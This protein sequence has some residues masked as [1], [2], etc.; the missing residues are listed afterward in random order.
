[1]YADC[2]LVDWFI[3]IDE[4]ERDEQE[5]IGSLEQ[6]AEKLTRTGDKEVCNDAV[7]T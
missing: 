5:G 1:M 3:V 6:E 2:L 4:R 7:V